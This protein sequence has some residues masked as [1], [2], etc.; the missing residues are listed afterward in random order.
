MIYAALGVLLGL[1]Q[2][3]YWLAV[4]ETAPGIIRW[5]LILVSPVVYGVGAYRLSQWCQN[6]RRSSRK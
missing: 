3:Y 1:I 6:R 4:P 2:S 5:A